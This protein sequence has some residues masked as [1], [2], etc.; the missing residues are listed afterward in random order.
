MDDQTMPTEDTGTDMPVESTEEMNESVDVTE[1][2]T[3]DSE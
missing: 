3:E 2:S 1:E